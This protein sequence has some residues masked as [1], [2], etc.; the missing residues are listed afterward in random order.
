M[1]ELLFRPSQHPDLTFDDVFLVPSNA[2]EELVKKATASGEWNEL[3]GLES[4]AQREGAT[5]EDIR[6]YRA[7]L[8]EL[9][10]RYHIGNG[11]SRDEVDL[12]PPGGLSQTPIVIANMNNVSGKRM[13]ESIAHV[14]GIAAIPQDK[15]NDEMREIIAYLRSRHPVYATAVQVSPQTKVHELRRLLA[16]RSHDTAVL[17]DQEGH[18]GGLICEADIPSGANEDLHIE[19]FIR[20]HALVTAQDGVTP[21]QAIEQMDREHVHF[22]P[23]LRA[24]GSVAGVLPKID[25]AMRL[26]YQPTVDALNG[27]LRAIFTVGALNKNPID[28]VQFLLDQGVQDI[29][30]DTAHFDQGIRSYR[31]VEQARE[32][33]TRKGVELR[34]LAGNVVT[35]EATRNILA[36][37]AQFVKVGIGPGAMCTTR[38]QTGVGRPQVSTIL[39]CSEEA[40]K[41]GGLLIA[42]GGIQH[43]R[44]AAIAIAAG[45]D[46]VMVGSLFAGTYESPPPLERDEHGSFKV[47]YGMAS[48]RASVLR[49]FGR[50]ARNAQEVFR[51]TVGLRT[52]GISDG[53]VYLKPGRGSVA[54]LQHHLLDGLASSMSYASARSI[55]EFQRRATIGLQT[56]SGYREGEPKHAL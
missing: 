30:F 4:R 21:L 48:T 24:D 42:D 17:V 27:G 51:E 1:A 53:R 18:F 22:L 14:G 13:A 41:W 5:L 47:N 2:T 49:T 46:S 55:A 33:A 40:H 16:K 29:L 39:E 11:F 52:E 6:L 19:P 38:M 32:L 8:L 20:R 28:R 3:V 10:E 50:E 36:A 56:A 35:R 26:R 44:D 34:L 45:A 31:N 12:T 43:P 9:A 7:K 15:S 37:G 54:S 23:I 25:A